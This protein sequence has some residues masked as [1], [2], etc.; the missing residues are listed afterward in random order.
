MALWFVVV[1]AIERSKSV[2]ALAPRERYLPDMAA[3]GY[4]VGG[5]EP[6]ALALHRLTTEQ[7]SIAIDALSDPTADVGI[8][9]AA[10]LQSMARIAA[11]L[12]M[13]RASI[14][15]EAY[16]TE[17]RILNET[18]Q[19]L[20]SLLDGQPELRALD[21]LRSRYQPVLQDGAFTELRAHLLR[22]HQLK[23][24]QALSEGEA[25]QRTLHRLRRARA[26]FAAWP[27]DDHTDARMYGRE[28]VADS[29]EAVSAGLGRTYKRARRQWTTASTGD[30]DALPKLH[31]EVR[32]LGH[33]VQVI[34][35]SW[36]DVLGATAAACVQLE[37]VLSEEA[38]LSALGSVLSD[39]TVVAEETEA[40]LL[41]AIVASTRTDLQQ[42]TTILGRRMFVEPPRLFIA[43]MEAYWQAKDLDLD[44]DESRTT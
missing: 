36:P 26:R 2:L 11:V 33:Q 5:G 24:L 10:T 20:A 12:R 25:L 19:L 37:T 32:H 42:I 31:R 8:A 1:S 4:R 35:S 27:L 22:R 39:P 28:P 34:S 9:T 21:Q 38:G 30:H 29:F 40:S 15:D 6:L 43:R 41:Q 13:V 14:G 17:L 3:E 16:R 44:L 18:T 7:F 23:R